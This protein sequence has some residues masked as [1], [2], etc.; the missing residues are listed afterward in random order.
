MVSGGGVERGL[1]VRFKRM[2]YK[3]LNAFIAKAQP[4]YKDA[5]YKE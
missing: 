2:F 4:S 3:M 5:E 1:R